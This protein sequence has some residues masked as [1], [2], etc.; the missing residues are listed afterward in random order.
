MEHLSCR[1]VIALS[2]GKSM[3]LDGRRE[4]HINIWFTGS[5]YNW[6]W[7]S[8]QT[9]TTVLLSVTAPFSISVL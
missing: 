4:G 2:A 5:L 9:E 8:Q 7:V 6:G 3:M 1:T